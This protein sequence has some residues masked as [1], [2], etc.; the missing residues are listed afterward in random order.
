M[1]ILYALIAYKPAW[2][3]G[4]P[5]VSVSETAEALARKG[6]RVTVFCS[7]SNLDQDL[8]VPVD[9]PLDVDGVE[10]WYCRREEPL[11]RWLPF[12]P[13]LSRSIGF[14]YC[15]AM[16][17]ALDR[18]MPSIDLVDTH[19]PFVYPTRAAA[20]AAFRHRRPLVYHQRGNFDPARLRFRGWKKR[21]Y[22]DLVERPLMRRATMLV[23]LTEAER[24]SYRA[25][26]VETPVEVVPNG[27][28]LPADRPDARQR[29]WARWKIA[30]DAPVVLFLGRLHPTKGAETLL[31]A[32]GQLH[33]RDPRAVLVMAGPDEWGLGKAWTARAG[34]DV[35]ASGVVFTGMLTGED[36]ADMLARADVFSLP[37]IG[38]GF[39]MAALEALA[40][41]TAV[42]LSPGCNFPEV[43]AAGAGVTVPA[44]AGAMADALAS[45]L[46][47]PDRLGAM[48][49]AGRA[50]VEASY[51]WDA[52]TDRLLAVYERAIALHEA[53]IAR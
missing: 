45:L 40:A 28:R 41:R 49:R 34:A 7:T 39:S 18:V 48:G 33:R 13:Y 46:G 2:R 19:M 21:R 12:V 42:M 10:V 38:E 50:L 44:D 5:V 9:R 29:V 32:F 26:G 51:S 23:G 11:R 47:D 4:G 53:T 17:G 30:L 27:V 43:D 14:G 36:K 24:R 1:R 15:P 3:V 31:D 37:S 16:R 52:I 22:I 20:R 35:A 25:L 8:D 6:H